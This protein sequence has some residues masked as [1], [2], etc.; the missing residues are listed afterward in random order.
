MSQSTAE[1]WIF[2]F[3]SKLCVQIPQQNLCCWH[4][5]TWSTFFLCSNNC[6]YALPDWQTVDCAGSTVVFYCRFVSWKSWTFVMKKASKA[7]QTIHQQ[8]RTRCRCRRLWL[9]LCHGVWVTFI[10]TLQTARLLSLNSQIFRLFILSRRRCR[11]FE[12][13]WIYE[14]A[15]CR[16]TH[17][18]SYRF[19][20]TQMSAAC[21]WFRLLVVGPFLVNLFNQLPYLTTSLC[22][23]CLSHFFPVTDSTLALLRVV[24][25]AFCIFTT[26]DLKPFFC[27]VTCLSKSFIAVGKQIPKQMY[28][29]NSDS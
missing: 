3:T 5:C 18:N 20:T 28:V 14:I 9:S 13:Q 4:L 29:R 22:L 6:R 26:S 27:F 25:S 11:R 1:M 21:E 16:H 23:L 7:K 12:S 15:N 19:G 24:A 17:T 10:E 2:F 8:Y